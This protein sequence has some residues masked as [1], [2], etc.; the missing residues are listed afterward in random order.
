VFAGNI[1]DNL[2]DKDMSTINKA[3]KINQAD[4]SFLGKISATHL[5]EYIFM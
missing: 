1:K 5:G 2:S 3:I 4:V